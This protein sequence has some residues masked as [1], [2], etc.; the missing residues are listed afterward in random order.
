MPAS[1]GFGG[2]L[3]E[4]G[5]T[6]DA[7][8]AVADDLITSAP[9]R[10]HLRPNPLHADLWAAAMAGR[11]GVTTKPSRAHVL[12]LDGGFTTV[13]QERFKA[14]TRNQVR[15]A[16]RM[17][18]VVET[19]ATGRLVPQLHDLLR[20]SV[21]R[22]AARQHEPARLAQARFARRDP[23]AKLQTIAEHLGGSCQVSVAYVEGR[24][25]AAILVLVGRNAHYTRGAMD[26]EGAS[27]TQA[28]RLLHKV[29]IEAACQAGCGSYHMGESG[30]SDGLAQF[31]S[32]FGAV[33]HP[34]DEYFIERVPL[35]RLDQLART[36]VKR[37]LRFRDA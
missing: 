35:T 6:V 17:G 33:A 7:V 28:N 24:P 29:A 19:D 5:V 26:E 4:G 1:W 25:V 30:E 32:R 34:Y 9:A 37:V 3:V 14:T 16:E 10:V 18:V 22:W 21:D 20:M 15:K 23:P 2:L 27:H 12:D 8:S 36:G 13:W 11:R 31:K